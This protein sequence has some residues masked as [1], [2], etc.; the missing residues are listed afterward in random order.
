MKVPLRGEELRLLRVMAERRGIS[1]QALLRELVLSSLQGEGELRGRLEE[2]AA[3]LS[4][5]SSQIASLERRLDELSREL[6]ELKELRP[7]LEARARTPEA[8]QAA[9][10]PA[11]AAPSP[12]AEN[13]LPSFLRDNPWVEILSRKGR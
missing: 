4:R 10:E 13:A 5:L 11:P 2:Q 12:T 7:A 9:P 8:G 1:L 6:R 3:L